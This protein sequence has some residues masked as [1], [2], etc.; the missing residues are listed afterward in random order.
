[1]EAAWGIDEKIEKSST[2]S[3]DKI[4]DAGVAAAKKT[5]DAWKGASA[6]MAG[7]YEALK[8][9]IKRTIAGA[10]GVAATVT[11]SL[12]GSPSAASSGDSPQLL[13]VQRDGWAFLRSSLGSLGV[14]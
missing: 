13:Q 2:A 8:L 7:S 5:A 4:G 9:S 14:V 6:V 1:M 12:S 3:L 10:K 11:T